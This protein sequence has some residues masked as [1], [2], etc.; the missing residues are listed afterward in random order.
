MKLLCLASIAAFLPVCLGDLV[1]TWKMVG[2]VDFPMQ[3]QGLLTTQSYADADGLICSLSKQ[4]FLSLDLNFVLPLLQFLSLPFAGFYL[5][6]SLTGDRNQV[7]ITSM[8]PTNVAIPGNAGYPVDNL[9]RIARPDQGYINQLTVNGI[10]AQITQEFI[11][12][13]VFV[14]VSA[15]ITGFTSADVGQ[16]SRWPMAPSRRLSS[17]RS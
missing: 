12:P 1:W 5:M 8:I 17:R 15:V 3:A 9:I 6:T 14:I 7:N 16:A 13:S 2:T 11:S 10:G 4:A